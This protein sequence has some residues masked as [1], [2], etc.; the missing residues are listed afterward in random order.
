MLL[1]VRHFA[2]MTQHLDVPS[3][4]PRITQCETTGF[5]GWQSLVFGTKSRCDAIILRTP[6]THQEKYQTDVGEL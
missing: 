4:N 1:V 5:Q 3:I 2:R 6:G